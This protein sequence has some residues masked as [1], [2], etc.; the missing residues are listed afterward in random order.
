MNQRRKECIS[1]LQDLSKQQEKKAEFDNKLDEESGLMKAATDLKSMDIVLKERPNRALLKENYYYFNCFNCF[2]PLLQNQTYYCF[3]CSQVQFC[4]YHCL[5]QSWQSG[6]SYFCLH[7]NIF[8]HLPFED[9]FRYPP[10]LALLNLLSFDLDQIFEDLRKGNLINLFHDLSEFSENE[11]ENF[12]M[13]QNAAFLLVYLTNVKRLPPKQDK[14]EWKYNIELFALLIMIYLQKF[15]KETTVITC[16]KLDEPIDKTE[17]KV[18]EEFELGYGIYSRL[19]CIKH[20]CCP[21]AFISSF[22][23]QE[24][25]VRSVSNLTKD[26]V[27]T[28]DHGINCKTFTC[29]ERQAKLLN[30]FG[31]TCKCEACLNGQEPVSKAYLCSNCSGPVIA[32]CLECGQ[33]NSLDLEESE[34]TVKSTIRNVRQA[35]LLLIRSDPDFRR[36]E[37]Y[38]LDSF[39]RLKTILYPSNRHFL[40][41]CEGLSY[42]YKKMRDYRLSYIYAKQAM[43]CTEQNDH[44]GV[45]FFNTLL[46]LIQRQKAFIDFVKKREKEN[47]KGYNELFKEALGSIDENIKKAEKQ[48]CYLSTN[49]DT[50]Y[51][52]NLLKELKL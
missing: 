18:L 4:S 32:K 52:K 35:S 20:A 29:E 14:I 9:V 13:A 45:T 10:L 19:N 38:L 41:I 37:D 15:E 36:A 31:I 17:S 25:I 50:E 7:L 21:N 42:C 49:L 28:I 26:T 1:K 30:S 43:K 46:K 34:E 23:G 51:F 8:K 11:H 12:K 24:I 3:R 16:I 2:K 22:N 40:Q 5:D 48:L 47:E 6:H 33:A 39:R 44:P 27:I